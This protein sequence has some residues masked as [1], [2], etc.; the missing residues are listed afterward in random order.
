MISSFAS[1]F[2]IVQAIRLWKLSD[3]NNYIKSNQLRRKQEYKK[4]Y[5]FDIFVFVLKIN[6][7]INCKKKFLNC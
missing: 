2:S 6:K 5:S 4:L 3:L 1:T 7:L